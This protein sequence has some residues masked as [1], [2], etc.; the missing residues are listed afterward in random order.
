M[1]RLLLFVISLLLPLIA[2]AEAVEINNL[3]YNINSS[4][5]TAEFT[6]CLGTPYPTSVVIPSTIN[7]NSQD[8]T[9]NA[10]GQNAFGYTPN[11]TSVT[12]PESVTSIGQGAFSGCTVLTSI[13][14]PNNVTTIGYHA[15]EKCSG[16]TSITLPNSVTTIGSEAFYGCTGLTSITIPNSVTSIGSAAFRECTGLTSITVGA[17]N[18]I[19]D[20]RD[21]CN[22]IIEKSTK[23]LI[24][25]CK[26]TIIPNTVE[27]IDAGA[28][29]GQTG[30]TSITIPESVTSITNNPFT[31]CSGLST[32]TV[33]SGNPN[34]YSCEGSNNY[35]AIIHKSSKTLITGCKNTVIPNE[36]TSIGYQAFYGCTGLTSITIPDNVTNIGTGAF[37]DCSS[38]T[39]V[40]IP[41]NVTAIGIYAFGCSN[42]TSVTVKRSEPIF[43]NDDTFTNRAA[44]TLYVPTGSKTAYEEANHW[45]D[46][47]KIYM[48]C[49][50][51]T[52]EPIDAVTYDGTPKEPTITVKDGT[53]PLTK[54]LDYDVSYADNI[55]AGTATVTVTG[56]K[57]YYGTK[58]ANFAIDPKALAD[59]MV[60]LSAS[61][62]TYNGSNQ[63]PTVTVKDGTTSLIENT[64]FTLTNAGG[65]AKGNYDI[66]VT[67]KGN[68]SGTITKQF[69]I[70]PKALTDAMVTLSANSFT[71]NGGNQKPTV[72]VK[73]GTTTLTEN[74]DYTLT[75]AG[76][77]AVGSYDVKV[78]GKG[79]YSGTITK[80]FTI[81]PKA[82]TD[83][84]VTLSASS[85]TYNG[86]NQ[87]PTVTVKDG[88]TSLIEN[89]DYT[90]TN[91]GGTAVGSYDVKVEG[92]GNYSG[93]I[94]KQFAINP[95]ALTDAMV[96]LSA[97]SFTYNGDNQKPTVT[98]KDGTN[99]LIENTD[100]TLT[101]A[102]GTA[103]GNYDITVT[104]K[105]NY[106]GTITKQF[107]INPK[108]LTDAMVTLSAS[109]FTYNGTNQKPTVTVKDGTTSLIE[110]TDYTL[111][112]AGG[113]AVGSYDVKVEGKGNYSGTI[114]KQ[115]TINPKALTDAMVTLS[116]SSFTYNGTNQKPTVTVKD[117][118]TSLIENTDYTLTNAGGTDVGSYD[119]KVTGK[120]N[121]SGTITKQF[122][123]DKAPLT[124]TAQSYTI[125]QGEALPTFT[126]T[127]S[128]FQNGETSTV[129]TKQPTISCSANADSELGDYD[130]TV[131]GAQA[132]NYDISYVNGKL[133]IAA[134]QYKIIYKVN[135]VIYKTISY[136][137]GDAITPEPAPVR[138]GFTFSGWSEIP[139]TMPAKD[140]TVTGSFIINKYK[141]TYMVDDEVYKSMKV[142]YGAPITP[143]AEPV[144]EG[145]TFSGWSE[146][147]ERMP[148]RNVI[149]YGT[150]TSATGFGETFMSV[151]EEDVYYD[152]HGL[153]VERP[154]KGIY[155]KNGQKVLIK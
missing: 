39:S 155:I 9:V 51:L 145:Y 44:A 77:T 147:P 68:Y 154:G 140:V 54:G 22:A 102:G 80:Q 6:Y 21:N 111:T 48:V 50:G 118:T 124:I 88:T 3:F 35:N 10:I 104:G 114:T 73:D 17:G 82:L 25:G 45:G 32:I 84:M 42:L 97:N 110:N 66:T 89:T 109:S 23:K 2:S 57:D 92:K 70:N 131:S 116:A 75:N 125:K 126:A 120:G 148:A 71:Y 108:A 28:F 122:T 143:E 135:G 81:N 94:T 30:L 149:V 46:F 142:K 103:K 40:T 62:F 20:S 29:S 139:A 55:Y 90:L 5:Y 1:N 123:I 60:T 11:L 115:F 150:F 69:A 132:D 113:T 98:V 127:Y 129:L 67:G 137:Y 130:I 38:L 95:K 33:A 119:V 37:L 65:T 136:D 91:A 105:G 133:T 19:Y 26:T 112:N 87:K 134:G 43:L 34:Y 24:A 47:S 144:K 14:I 121:Y 52:I 107:T 18:T 100:Y 86:T 101:N 15:F 146:I 106:S 31:E 49:S 153:P 74:T 99:S 152:L 141:L 8:Y 117:G 76:G 128:G 96:T 59:G 61:S 36:V 53:T 41:S 72:T 85:F 64:D 58:T 16:L 4:T 12:I 56:S 13:T 138:E 27:M 78:E 93:T 63:K 83:A 151:E 79:N 7:Y